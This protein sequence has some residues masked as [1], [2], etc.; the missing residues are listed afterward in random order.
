M[1]GYFE[2]ITHVVSQLNKWQVF[3]CHL[4]KRR[5]IV[6]YAK[7]C[8]TD[9]GDNTASEITNLCEKADAHVL[10]RGEKERIVVHRKQ[11]M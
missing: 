6:P 8:N 1:L 5:K 2:E 10:K 7:V 4:C 9:D 3:M 11:M